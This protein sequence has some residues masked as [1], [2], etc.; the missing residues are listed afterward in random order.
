MRHCTRL[1]VVLASLLLSAL[2]LAASAQVV[3]SQ[4]YGGGGNSGATFTN[5][6]VELFNRGT[7]PVALGGKS[8]QYASSTGNFNGV[9][10]LPSVTLQPGQYYLVQL[11]GGATGVA[12]PVVADASSAN[13]NLSGTAGKVAVVDGTT[14]LG[15]GGTTLACTTGQAAQIIDL[16]GYGSVNLSEGDVDGPGLNNTTSARRKSGGCTDTDNNGADFEA[17]TPPA[18]RN[19]AST[20]NACG[21]PT[22][23]NP[24]AVG[25]A[26]PASVLPGDTTLLTV[27]VIPGTTPTSTGLTVSADLTAIGGTAAQAFVDDG[28]NGD[29]A[30]GD[31]VFSHRA[32]V[33]ASTPTGALSLTASVTDAQARSASASIALSVVGKVRISEIQG[34]GIGSPLPAGTE[35]ITEGIVTARRANGYFI[36]SRSQDG[37]PATAEG[38]FV[39]T[40]AAPPANAVVGNFVRVSGRV[41]L[42]S[43]TPH[44]YPLTQLSNSSLTVLSTG[45]SLPTSS[46]IGGFLVPGFPLAELGRFQ[47]MRVRIATADVVGPTN[48]FG[49]FYITRSNLPR[50]AREPGI[51]ALDA[52][53]LPVGNTIPRF[54]RNHE[55]LRVESVGLEGAIALNVDNGTRLENLE[56]ILYYDRGDFTLLLGDRTNLVVSGGANIAAVPTAGPG[57]LRIG[58][59]NIEN[60]SGGA[61]VNLARLSKLT[62]VFCSYL[63]TPD[64]VGLVEIADLATA[65]RVAQA[66]NDNE[67]GTCPN[68]PQYVAQLLATSGSQR[69]GFLISTAPAPGGSGPR[70]QVLSIQERF[71]GET[72]TNPA[73]AADGVLFDRPPLHLEARVTGE[74]GSSYDVDVL[75]NH[76][77]SLLDV[78]DLTPR[79]VW[80]TNGDRSRNKRLQQA[81]RLSQLV[82]QIQQADPTQPLVLIGDYNAFEFSDGYADVMGI[83]SGRPAALGTVLVHAGSAVTVPLTNMIGTKPLAQRYSYVFEGNIQT[84]DHALVNDAVLDTTEATLYHARVNADFATDNAADPQV[85][86]RTSDHDPLVLALTVPSF[87]DADLAVTATPRRAS[88]QAPYIAN[89]DVIVAND[90]PMRAIRPEITFLFDVPPARVTRVR[91]LKWTCSAPIADPVGSRVFCGRNVDMDGS[92]SDAFLV[93][94]TTAQEASVSVQAQ[95]Q[96]RSVDTDA[97]DNTAGAVTAVT[98]PPQPL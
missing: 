84:L 29:A 83:I 28:S 34:A 81:V 49:D 61:N 85:P 35:V 31:N 26:S 36:Q 18:P 68:S 70:V 93:Q 10:V 92:V 46:G 38:L 15:C 7:A 51:A 56:G 17:I 20:L 45:N 16:L 21:A 40:N 3:V 4:A 97:T 90:G 42:F 43:R 12:L 57:S 58:S 80:G 41:S 74:N 96:T 72:L 52:V 39:F 78:N 48:G 13:P 98:Q 1:H 55:R 6:F 64:I 11:A 32:T 44:G 8:I 50:P 66:I 23:T 65:Q 88:V 82:E 67:F 59:F 27:S 14:A 63:R 89:F 47:G 87:L 94:L 69:L 22:P 25:A 19:T 73:N 54:D 9:Y 71:L 53:P 95:V 2:P 24:T 60:L 33:P 5:D 91:A 77:L 62:E 86:L 37:N 76:T 79:A 30:A 75:L